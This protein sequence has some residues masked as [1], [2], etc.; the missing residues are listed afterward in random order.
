MPRSPFTLPTA[1]PARIH[2]AALLLKIRI[3][4]PGATAYEPP[5]STCAFSPVPFP[6]PKPP[7]LPKRAP[8]IMIFS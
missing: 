1:P 8:K 3:F 4:H 2:S 5:F 7:K 6:S